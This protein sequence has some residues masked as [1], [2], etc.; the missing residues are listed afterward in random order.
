MFDETTEDIKILEKLGISFDI[1]SGIMSVET[2]D[3]KEWGEDDESCIT[4]QSVG[5][6]YV[7]K[8]EEYIV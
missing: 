7:F 3:Y 2:P 6:K 4:I 1:V 8:R 5:R